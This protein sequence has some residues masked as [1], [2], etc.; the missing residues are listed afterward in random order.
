[1]DC[2]VE[3]SAREIERIADDDEAC[4]RLRH[5]PG[6]GPL[7]STATVAAIGTGAVFRRGRDFA[8]WLGLVPRQ[9]STGGTGRLF[10]ISK[11]GNVYLRRMFLSKTVYAGR[12]KCLGTTGGDK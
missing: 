9:H 5:I 3:I 10:G 7:V 12:Y 6:V 1:M 2:E 8:A 11:H 4:Q